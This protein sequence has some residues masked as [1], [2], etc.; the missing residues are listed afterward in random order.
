MVMLE[1]LVNFV[2]S[3]LEI[4]AVAVELEH[5]PDTRMQ[6]TDPQWIAPSPQYRDDDDAEH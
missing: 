2:P 4:V 5:D 3:V 6:T 1:L